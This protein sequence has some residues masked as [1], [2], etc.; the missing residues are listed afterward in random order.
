[1]QGFQNNS[2]IAEFEVIQAAGFPKQLRYCIIQSHSSCGGSKTTPLLQY[3]KLFNLQAFQNNSAIAELKV[4]QAAG[5]TKQLRYCSIQS[6]SSG[7]GSKTTPLLQYS[8][9]FMLQGFQNNSAIAEFKVIQ[10]AGIPIQLRC[11]SIQSDS[12]GRGTTATPLL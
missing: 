6:H 7:R 8:K 9:S 1:L 11:C 12:S 5:V 3:S 10:A 2:A 4:F